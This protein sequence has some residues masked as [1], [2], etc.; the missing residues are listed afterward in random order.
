M[1]E[2]LH[3]KNFAIIE[4]ADILFSPGFNVLTGETG[5]GKS[6][7]IDCLM[8]VLG[9]RA[10]MGMIRT[11]CDRAS[12]D[13]LFLKTEATA[14]LFERLVQEEFI[15]E[16][17]DS[18]TL[19]RELY[20]SG[21]SVCRLNFR[22]V[23]LTVLKD[24]GSRFVDILE[25][26]QQLSL[27]SEK[28]QLPL[29]DSYGAELISEP[30]SAY[31]AAYRNLKD[32]QAE[33]KTLK[34]DKNSRQERID[35]LSYTIHTIDN[36]AISEG[37]DEELMASLRFMTNAETIKELASD[38]IELLNGGKQSG[39]LSDMDKL[40]RAFSNLS[41]YDD[42]FRGYE[43]DLDGV[44]SVLS[45]AAHFLSDYDA[46]LDFDPIVLS[47]TEER[48][49]TLERLKKRYGGTLSDVLSTRDAAEKEMQE[50]LSRDERIAEIDGLLDK[51]RTELSLKAKVLLKAREKAG[52]ALK[53][54]LEPA[55]N[56]LMLPD[57]VFDV[58]F[59][60]G[61]YREVGAE[62]IR[63]DISFNKGEVPRP[64]S[65]VASG[66][67]LSRLLLALKS[68][69]SEKDPVPV[70]IFDEVDSGLGGETAEAVADQL[71]AISKGHQTLCIT[72]A[73]R[74]AAAADMHFAIQ[75]FESDSRTVS[76]VTPLVNREDRAQELVRMLGG[77]KHEESYTLALR[78]LQDAGQ[79]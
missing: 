55:L 34:G 12:I 8:L 53:A 73:A 48:L 54:A 63:F 74:I 52:K 26:G 16:E 37:E 30:L 11:G 43:N 65:Q 62:T 19:S 3:I 60:P 47:Q 42:A 31:Q 64:L 56:K 67:E 40:M 76:Q 25:Q 78:M 5:A 58:A 38:G 29:L 79:Q 71:S 33:E 49:A 2:R 68:V 50:L 4:E 13:A 72:H 17:D 27:L 39:L 20:S 23:P 24:L 18:I 14:A 35:Y 46:R 45:D 21:R 70:M 9:A 41:R 66:G 22:P 77:G 69:F 75:K 51:A 32:L 1:L 36:A 6:I 7:L 57:A 59:I 28:N 15:T 10:D 61:D 44:Y